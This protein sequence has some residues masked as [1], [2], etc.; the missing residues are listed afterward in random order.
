MFAVMVP[1]VYRIGD[2]WPFSWVTTKCI[3]D[4]LFSLHS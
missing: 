1:D 3:A 2:V 4:V